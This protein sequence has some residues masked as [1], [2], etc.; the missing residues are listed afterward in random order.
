MATIPAYSI[1]GFTRPEL[2]T[3]SAGNIILD[4]VAANFAA[5]YGIKALYLGVPASTSYPPVAASLTTPSDTNSS[6]NSVAEGA[7]NGTAVGITALV[8]QI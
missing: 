6:A 8:D 2:H 4:P 1:N 7:A 3:D 5:T